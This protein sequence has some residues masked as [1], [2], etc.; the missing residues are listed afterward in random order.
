[1]KRPDKHVEAAEEGHSDR[2]STPLASTIL[3]INDLEDGKGATK[4]RAKTMPPITH[5]GRG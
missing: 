4:I 5:G 2:G 3:I 1:M